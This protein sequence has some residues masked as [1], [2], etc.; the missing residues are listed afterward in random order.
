MKNLLRSP[1]P[2]LSTLSVLVLAVG[3]PACAS[4]GASDRAATSGTD[5]SSPEAETTEEGP[6]NAELEALYRARTDSALMEFTDAD[7]RFMTSM[8]GHHAQALEMARLAPTHDASPTIRTLAAR[9]INAQRDEIETMQRWLRE[10]GQPVPEVGASGMPATADDTRGDDR[11]PDRQQAGGQQAPGQQTGDDTTM[12]IPGMLT[13]EQ[14]RELD[15]ARGREF[16]RLFLRYMI[17][18]HEGA[19]VA[20]RELFATDG[21]ARGDVTFKLASGIQVD[22]IT[23]I[24]RMESML[25]SMES[26]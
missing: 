11:S 1:F 10:R 13:P 14:M 3:V 22:Q 5:A 2:T 6:S 8:I 24:E 19:V 17:Q 12:Q 9:I 7:V 18:H 23:E 20:V 16:D 21:A 26:R 15:E 25:D 4:T